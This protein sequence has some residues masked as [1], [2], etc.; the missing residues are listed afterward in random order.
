MHKYSRFL[1]IFPFCL[2]ATLLCLGF[3]NAET[4]AVQVTPLAEAPVSRD[5]ASLG[6]TSPLA[7]PDNSMRVP[8]PAWTT[9]NLMPMEM[10]E[11]YSKRPSA[12]GQPPRPL[13]T[14]VPG[15]IPHGV[16][17]SRGRIVTP[18]QAGLTAPHTTMPDPAATPI[19]PVQDTQS[20][21]KKRSA[22]RPS[23]GGQH[24]PMV[25]SPVIPSPMVPSVPGVTPPR[26]AVV[27]ATSSPVAPATPSSPTTSPYS[28][29]ADPTGPIAPM[30][31]TVG[32]AAQPSGNSPSIAAQ[33]TDQGGVMDSGRPA[34]TT[35]TG[36]IATGNASASGTA[37]TGTNGGA[38]QGANGANG[39]EV[40]GTLN[41]TRPPVLGGPAESLVIPPAGISLTPN[42]VPAA[43]TAP[44]RS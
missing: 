11:R 16:V 10:W 13:G 19:L 17:D 32:A 22:A 34:A 12:F 25:S 31:P 18:A 2:V 6:V 44:P 24:T 27:Q 23:A 40:T 41:T 21:A 9:G 3:L 35:T 1:H 7:G 15:Y 26:S 4:L 8:T 38:A 29:P 14:S 5:S 43:L 39:S 33:T 42:D 37:A 30:Q 20:S 36:G 28:T